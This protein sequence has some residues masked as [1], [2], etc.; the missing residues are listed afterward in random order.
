MGT[1]YKGSENDQLLLN[2]Y[3]KLVRSTESVN[4]KLSRALALKNL[5]ITQ[6]GVLEVLYHL[7]PL[8]QR[9]I[10]DKLLKS[11]GNITMVID[12]LQKN[13]FVVRKKCPGDRRAVLVHLTDEGEAFISQLF[14]EHLSRL[15]EEFSVL[16]EKE[17]SDLAKI[18]KKLGKKE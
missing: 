4:S 14:P 6:F 11:G 16:S 12:N 10:G 15:R 8:N 7:G 17:M 9:S 18:C 13:G 3:I 5:T 2:A 1:H